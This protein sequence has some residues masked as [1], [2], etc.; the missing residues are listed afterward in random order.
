MIMTFDY[1]RAALKK[2]DGHL[3]LAKWVFDY[4]VHIVT[5][6]YLIFAMIVGNG[7][8]LINAVLLGLTVTTLIY[9][10]VYS[11]KDLSK[12]ARK[13]VEKELK[14]VKRKLRV[15]SLIVKGV[16]FACV[17]YG[18]YTSA[19]TVTPINI[20][21]TT[22]LLIGWILSVIGELAVWL[23]EKESAYLFTGFKYDITFG[24]ERDA[25]ANFIAK[26][27]NNDK[28]KII[29]ELEELVREKREEKQEKLKA[30]INQI[31]DGVKNVFTKGA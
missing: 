1:T 26:S 11:Q 4:G 31:V 14:E 30:G 29:L 6:V 24:E 3:R 21:L 12:K 27:K 23:F 22:L 15:G 25:I 9:T 13:K 7:R 20:I 19:T 5:I 10:V 17:L 8:L 28:D 2:I 16:S 18:M